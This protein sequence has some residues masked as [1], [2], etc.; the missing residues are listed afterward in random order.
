MA[1][2]PTGKIALPTLRRGIK[3][4]FADTSRELRKVSWPSNRETTRL[5]GIVLTVC[6][7]QAIALLAMAKIFDTVITILEQGK[8]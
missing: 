8:L 3:G 2:E 5:T 1:N 4:F 7:G 6:F